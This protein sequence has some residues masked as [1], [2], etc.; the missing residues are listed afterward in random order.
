MS[1]WRQ[2]AR[3][4]GALI[5]RRRADRDIADQVESYLELSAADFE[6]RGLSANEARR[7]A[8]LDLGSPAGMR[9]QVQSSGWENAVAGLL[10]DL[11]HAV[12]RLRKNPGFTAV[13]VL[14]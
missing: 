10:S 2:I 6:A 11:R 1:S 4:L 14:T 7:A 8:R 12:R 13:S 3:G 9:D 5:N